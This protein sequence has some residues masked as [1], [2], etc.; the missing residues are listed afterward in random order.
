MYHILFLNS[1]ESNFQAN[2]KVVQSLNKLPKGQR[3]LFEMLTGSWKDPLSSLVMKINCPV[4]CHYVFYIS[5]IIFVRA[6]SEVWDW[7]VYI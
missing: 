5:R 1:I 3:K 7:S 6:T 2:P 4:R